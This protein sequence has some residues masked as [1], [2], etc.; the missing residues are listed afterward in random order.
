MET[1]ELH[2]GRLIDHFIDAEAGEH[3]EDEMQ[4]PYVRQQF[5]H[6]CIDNLRKVTT[7]RLDGQVNVTEYGYDEVDV[8]RLTSLSNSLPGYPGHGTPL[9]LSYDANGNL[10]DDGQGRTLEWDGMGRLASV[11]L[12]DGRHLRYLHGPDSRVCCVEDSDRSTYR[13]REDGAI[14]FEADQVERR[15]FIR[16]GGAV[17]AETRIATSIREVLLL[18]T[19]P[20]GSVVTESSAP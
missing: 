6:D 19:D 14:A 16:T 9:Q 11:T 1:H 20:Q 18:G 7:T 5:E 12:P 15:R 8:D 17:V 2:R 13:Y 4:Q 10:T 3:P